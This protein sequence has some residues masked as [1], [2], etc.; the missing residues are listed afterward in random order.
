MPAADDRTLSP[1]LAAQR[2]G[3]AQ[4][5]RLRQQS[6]LEHAW[7]R[8]PL[9]RRLWGQPPAL[10]DW[11]TLPVVRKAD[12]MTGFDDWVTDPRLTLSGVRAFLR[13]PSRIGAD[14]LGDYAVWTSSGTTGEPGVFVQDRAALAVYAT[15]TATRRDARAG[16]GALWQGLAW[17]P[18]RACMIAATEGHYAGVSFWRRQCRLYPWLAARAQ[19]VP[20]TAPERAWVAALNGFQPDFIASY[21]SVL[22]A[23]ARLRQDGRLHIAPRALW[24]GGERLAPGTRAFVARVFGAPITNDYGASECMA[25]A[26]ECTRGRLHVHDDWVLLEPVD[27]AGRPVPPGEPSHSVLLTNLANRVAP[28]VRYA[29]GDSVTVDPDPCPCGN[30]HQTVRVA[31]RSDDTLVLRDAEGRPVHVSPLAVTTA[32]EEGADVHRFQLRQTAPDAVEL[33]LDKA[34]A[35]RRAAA[36]RALRVFLAAQGLPKVHVSFDPGAPSPEPG[37]GKLRQVIALAEG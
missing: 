13:D 9:Y 37:S 10:A 6:L 31:G 29:L 21:P 34:E 1:F 4:R 30:P 28:I 17:P 2:R 24:A 20:V 3:A 14:H 18:R 25:I 12:L 23:L 35:G 33:R 27:A 11:T 7:R 36:R 8:S 19:L 22:S 16:F 32:I 5:C 15:L 26:F